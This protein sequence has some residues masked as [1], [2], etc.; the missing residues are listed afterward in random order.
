MSDPGK[1]QTPT[2]GD[3]TSTNLLGGIQA[4]D[5]QSWSR[6]VHLYG[7]LV[8]YWCRQQGLAAEDAADVSQ[9][10]FRAVARGVNDF[11]H[12]GRAGSFRAW[13]WTI[14][15]NKIRDHRRRKAK[16]IDAAG[17]STAKFRLDQVPDDPPPTSLAA[18][19]FS[20]T[21][22]KAIDAVRTQFEDHTWQA[23]WRTT[24]DERAATDVAAE[25]G[26]SVAAIYKAKSRVLRRLREDFRDLV[27]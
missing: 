22:L 7:G 11:R 24:V 5:S 12:D 3:S 10:A 20:A 14:T 9:E 18:G 25:L 4:N 23:F 6:F 17:G 13:L 1:P 21:F 26:M 2:S 27:D 8:Y 15:R 16:Q 19:K